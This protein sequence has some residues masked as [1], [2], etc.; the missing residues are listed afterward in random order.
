VCFPSCTQYA[1]CSVYSGTFCQPIVN[2]SRGFICG[3]SAG[4]IGD[5]CLTDADCESG[6]GGASTV[7]CTPEGW[8]TKP[9]SSPAD[10]SCGTNNGGVTNHC[11]LDPIASAYQCTPGCTLQTDC[12]SF[13]AASCRA[14]AGQGF[15][16]CSL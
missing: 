3:T 12:I 6:D 13:P 4:K 2:S 14:I 16:A 5:P 15:S 11:V 8:C 10:T 1:D 7:A 9:C